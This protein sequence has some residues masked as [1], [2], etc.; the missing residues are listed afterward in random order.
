M[1]ERRP[2]SSI[3]RMKCLSLSKTKA[4]S[5]RFCGFDNAWEQR[6][7]GDIADS[8]SGGTPRAGKKE[9]Y[10][11]DIPFIRSGEISSDKIEL[12]LSEEG[13]N[14][15]SAKMVKIGDILYAL[16]GATSGEVSI[17]KLNGAINQAI[18]AIQ[19]HQNYDSQFLMQW[20]RNSKKAIIGTYLQG[21]Q[22]NLSGN[23][24]K[25]LFVNMPTY[26]EQKQIG[27]FF[28]KLD[29]L[30]TL[31][32]RKYEK[33]QS[34]KASMLEKMFPKDGA[35][36]PEVRFKGFYGL[37]E[38]MSA[39]E[40][41]TSYVDK[42]HPELPV[43]SATQD[44]GMVIRNEI[45]KSVFHE[46][47]N[48]VGYKRVSPGQFVIHLRSFQGG[49]A[50]STLEGITSPAYTVFGFKEPENHDD[51]FWK[52]VFMSKQFIKRLETVTYGIRDGRSISYE[53]FLT[54][55]FLFPSKKEQ[56]RISTYLFQL[57][58]LIAIRKQETE[59]LQNI[60]NALLEKMFV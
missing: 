37:W 40:L 52:Y 29:H 3:R 51:Y 19:P 55:D 53:E 38:K 43:L 18:L 49:F 11:G 60:K 45:G 15:S 33:L 23:I 17:S 54:L 6:K 5:I 22:G 36:V 26:D 39:S 59:K 42:G 25:E 21:G 4:P 50:H 1:P 7:L 32:Q 41:F 12:F 56:T 47:A 10:D 24:V 20:L 9:Y 34:L 27:D 28:R 48:E 44:A 31:H 58:S 35:D 46:T 14:N 16:Y 8:Y 30:I 2:A 57:D 13:L